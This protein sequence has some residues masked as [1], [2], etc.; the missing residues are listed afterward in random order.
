MSYMAGPAWGACGSTGFPARWCSAGALEQSAASARSLSRRLPPKSRVSISRTPTSAAPGL[1]R[2]RAQPTRAQPR[3]SYF[4]R[5]KRDT[6]TTPAAFSCDLDRELR[7]AA[8]RHEDNQVLTDAAGRRRKTV[9]Y[10]YVHIA[11]DDYSRL[12]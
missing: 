2:S 3:R 12:A 6:C 1:R 10:E 5:R 8:A 11:V 9:G 7:N 4:P